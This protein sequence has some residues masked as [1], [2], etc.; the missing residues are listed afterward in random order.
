MD[1]IADEG[2]A[3]NEP[4]ERFRTKLREML[5]SLAERYHVE[6]LGLFGSYL[7]G[8]QKPESD[9]DVLVTFAKTPSLLELIELEHHLSDALGVKVDLALRGS[10]KPRI[11]RRILREVVPV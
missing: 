4:L 9:L 5:P 10:L 8:T 2:R 6:T 7:H 11:G 1:G 3:V